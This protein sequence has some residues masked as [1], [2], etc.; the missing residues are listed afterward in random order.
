MIQKD[1]D[2]DHVMMMF[3]MGL[4]WSIHVDSETI[5]S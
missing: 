4:A 5:I 1:E 3:I 2:E